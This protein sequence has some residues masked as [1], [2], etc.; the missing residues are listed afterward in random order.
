MKKVLLA[1]AV[2][3]A[4]AFGLGATAAHAEDPVKLTLSGNIV[5]WVGYIG[6]DTTFLRDEGIT[7]ANNFM[8]YQDGD[9]V[10]SGTTKLDNGLT[11]GA[12]IDLKAAPSLQETGQSATNQANYVNALSYIT[13]AGSFGQVNAG[14]SYDVIHD[15]AVDAPEEGY[16]F[17]SD[18]YWGDPFANGGFLN[19]MFANTTGRTVMFDQNSSTNL[20]YT[21]PNFS[22]FQVGVDFAEGNSQA[23]GGFVNLT[24]S[25][26]MSTTVANAQPYKDAYHLVGT[27]GGDFGDAK[28]K[29]FVGYAAEEGRSLG[30]AL[31]GT[32]GTVGPFYNTTAVNGGVSVTVKGFT[33]GG[34]VIDRMNPSGG[35]TTN[36]YKVAGQSGVTWDIGGAYESGPWGVS[37][38]YLSSTAPDV[39]SPSLNDNLAFYE[40]GAHYTLGPGITLNGNVWGQAVKADWSAIAP[41]FNTA[42]TEATVSGMGALISTNVS[43]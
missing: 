24:S 3:V 25:A 7:Q 11:I 39:N 10:F 35:P 17:V 19:H 14:R 21:T 37:I 32:G 2:A 31:G 43:F 42:G 23:A 13:V 26:G 18:G 36:A 9:F 1:S 16:L 22:G 40:I 8:Q 30:A 29:A 15:N 33:V 41:G 5:Q 6:N 38:A 20:R 4:S 34:S 27:Y 28:V 12:T